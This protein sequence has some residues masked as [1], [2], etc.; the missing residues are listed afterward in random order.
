MKGLGFT[1]LRFGVE[2]LWF[3]EGRGFCGFWFRGAVH[4]LEP[5]KASFLQGPFSLQ[6]SRY[7]VAC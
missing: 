6:G 7:Q 3:G 4:G 5:R 2:G 1:V